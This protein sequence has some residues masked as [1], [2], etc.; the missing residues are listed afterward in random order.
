M[1][2]CMNEGINLH[3]YLI[4]QECNKSEILVVQDENYNGISNETYILS[5]NSLLPHI[6]YH[7]DVKESTFLSLM[8]SLLLG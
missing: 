5:Y 7:N 8:Y 6:W 3:N 1:N 4:K 2:E